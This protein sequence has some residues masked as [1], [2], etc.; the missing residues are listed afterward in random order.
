MFKKRSPRY[1][2]KKYTG[3]K[4]PQKWRK[5]ITED[6]ISHLFKPKKLVSEN[7][8]LATMGSCFAQRLEVWLRQKKF[9]VIGGQRNWGVVY[10]PKNIKQ[11]IQMALDPTQFTSAEEFWVW[12]NDF[13]SPYIK[14]SGMEPLALPSGVHKARKALKRMHQEWAKI[15]KKVD[16]LIITLGQTEYWAHKDAPNV[17]FYTAPFMGIKDGEKNHICANLSYSEIKEELAQAVELLHK[18]NPHLNIVFSVSPIPLVASFS[19]NY[20]AYIAAGAAKSKLHAA[21][22]DLIE[23]YEF[24]HYM[25]SYEIVNSNPHGHFK[26][27]GRHV[28]GAVAAKIMN[29]FKKLYV[30]NGKK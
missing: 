4:F 13:R 24:L 21:A 22:L 26:K 2:I 8:T 29:H 20:S 15:F 5:D 3:K 6:D 30:T 11:L 23:E 19:E 9:N 28:V 27:D 17:A 16:V 25:P 14:A 1:V 7:T 18:H 12:G 10:N